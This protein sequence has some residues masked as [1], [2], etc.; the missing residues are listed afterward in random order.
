MNTEDFDKLRIGYTATKDQQQAEMVP[1][2]PS[3]KGLSY[4][5]TQRIDRLIKLKSYRAGCA[6]LTNRWSARVEDKVPSPISSARGA[7]LIR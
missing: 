3:A 7:Q 5:R 4:S 1:S 2:A 6:D